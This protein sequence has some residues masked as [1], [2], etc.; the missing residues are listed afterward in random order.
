MS[1]KVVAENASIL[2]D[3]CIKYNFPAPLLVEY[4]DK[5]WQETYELYRLEEISESKLSSM[6]FY[7][8]KSPSFQMLIPVLHAPVADQ[9]MLEFLQF[10]FT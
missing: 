4:Y 3:L 2:C 6:F 1:K 5:W 10:T 7:I 8:R 9:F